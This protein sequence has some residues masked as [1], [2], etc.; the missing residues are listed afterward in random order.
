MYVLYDNVG[1]V[2]PQEPG[3]HER[4]FNMLGMRDTAVDYDYQSSI[5]TRDL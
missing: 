3:Q 2:D 4:A 1:K 5:A